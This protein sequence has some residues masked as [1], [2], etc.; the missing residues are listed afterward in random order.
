[1]PDFQIRISVPLHRSHTYLIIKSRF[2]CYMESTTKACPFKHVNPG[3]LYAGWKN[4]TLNISLDN[5]FNFEVL[6]LV[7]STKYSISF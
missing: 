1:M 2:N 4:V 6:D 3:L 7:N 5:R